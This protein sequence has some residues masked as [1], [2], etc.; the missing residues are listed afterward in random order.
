MGSST[1]SNASDLGWV[2][3]KFGGTSVGKFPDKIARDIVKASLSRNRV[4]VVC[5]ARS[6]GK[7]AEGTTSRLLGVYNKLQHVALA[8]AASTDEDPDTLIEQA[9]GLIMDICNDH[10]FAAESFVKDA[11]LRSDLS[12]KIEA[13]CQ[14]LIEYII[15]AKRFN[16]EINSRAKDRVISFG[17][18]LACLYM[19]VLLQD[20]GVDAEYIDLC[21]ALHHDAAAHLDASFYKS[22]IAAFSRKLSACEG[23]V[24]VV[25]GFFGN[26]PGSLIDG[27]IG[28]GYTDLC[29]ALCAVS[30]K[31]QELQIWKEVDG[32]FTADPSKVPTA[33]LLPSITPS[34][35]A[36]L[37]FYGSEV[38]HHLT[39]DQVIRA[40]PPIP[41]RIKNV[42]NPRGNGT[43][44][45]PDPMMSASH[46]LQRARPSGAPLPS[47][48]PKRPTAVTIKDH[49]SVI[50]VHSNKRSISHG[51]FAR[52]F[53]ILDKHSISVDLISTSEVHVSLAIHSGS[54]RVDAF[55]NAKQSLAECGEVS[56]L[57]DMA[58]LSLVG[59][60]MKNMIGVAGKMFSTLGEHNVNL[61]MISQGASEINISCVID[62]RDATRAMNVLH[63]HLFTFLE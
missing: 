36:E 58:I 49:I 17:E 19:T 12:R 29:A 23:R 4:V 63:T 25:T 60:D 54:T 55:A 56:V 24:P 41:I 31:A 28:R 46:Q 34:E 18:K 3:Q 15:A 39:M 44:V 47:K 35:A 9:K 45:I 21:D 43:I 10:I 2:V 37:T 6:T 62:S 32:I 50:N 33:R 48:S 51:F 38:I 5:S 11:S 1:Y 27:D 16:L 40:Q 42:K 8:Y 61:E 7:K 20:A 57:S 59:A 14:E 22:A 52:V 13:E 53:S 30:L 26:V